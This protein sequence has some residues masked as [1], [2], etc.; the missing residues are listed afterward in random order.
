MAEGEK[1]PAKIQAV[2][3]EKN[4]WKI[5]PRCAGFHTHLLSKFGR[6]GRFRPYPGLL[7]DSLGVAPEDM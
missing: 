2:K 6:Y 4:P 1:P 5:G 7:P 3:G